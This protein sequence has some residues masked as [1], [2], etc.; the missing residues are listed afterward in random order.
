M[1]IDCEDDLVIVAEAADGEEALTQAR[2]KRPDVILMD[3][4]M[5]GTDG[6]EATRAV[7]DEG[8]TAE[9]GQPIGI[10]ILTTYHIDE[11]VYASL[12]A[13]ASGFLLKDASPLEI[14]TAIRA[15]AAGEAWLDPAVTRRLIDEFAA[16]PGQHTVT[17]AEMAQLTPR[18]REVLSLLALGMSNAEVGR[19][20]SLSE[21]TVKTYLYHVMTKLGV[22]EKAQAVAAAYQT[23]LVQPPTR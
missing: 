2:A 15:V 22:R 4:R 17:P 3:I 5:P 18:E 9:N 14:V 23:G 21:A 12:R 19:K 16:R 7:I 10:I 13:G 20:L 1:L 11:A 8:L 6:V